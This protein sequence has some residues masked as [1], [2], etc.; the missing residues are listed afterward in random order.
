LEETDGLGNDFLV[1]VSL[2]A[3]L[4]VL[5]V[6]V[7]AVL[8]LLVV[9]DGLLLGSGVLLGLLVGGV[10]DS[11]V[12]G[13]DLLLEVSDGLVDLVELVGLTGA[14]L[15]VLFN[16]MLVSSALDFSG[17]GDLVKEVVAEGED[18]LDSL[19]VS[20]DGSGGGD[21][22]EE[23]EDGGPALSGEMFL[24]GGGL[25]VLGDL[26]EGLTGEFLSLLEERSGG[27]TVLDDLLGVLNDVLGLVVLFLFVSPFLV[28]GDLVL[29]KFDDL[30]FDELGELLLVMEHSVLLV[31]DGDLLVE[32]GL[33]LL[34]AGLSV[35]NFGLE[36]GDLIVRL[37]LEFLNERIIDVLLVFE[38]V[39]D[40]LEHVDEVFDWVSGLELEL[41][42]VQEGLS[43]LGLLDLLKSV[44][45]IIFVLVD[46]GG[47]SADCQDGEQSD[48]GESHF[49]LLWKG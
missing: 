26:G 7:V 41:D 44:V 5:D 47:K 28:A 2:A 11:L 49:V 37:V 35:G 12:E 40:V 15:L 46:G 19:G 22:G 3:S 4:G 16:P 33:E 17:F 24:L 45:G 32:L 39:L 20:L 31:P 43:E 18:L 29:V 6:L 14:V 42:G 23:L 34:G 1:V 13:G 10:G 8:E 36:L 48:G 27:Q 9:L 21:L 38:V 25:E 30:L